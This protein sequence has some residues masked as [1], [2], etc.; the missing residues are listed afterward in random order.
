MLD[1]LIDLALENS[2]LILDALFGTAAAIVAYKV[3][4]KITPDNVKDLIREAIKSSKQKIVEK[5]VGHAVEA[6]IVSKKSNAV[7]F[8]IFCAACGNNATEKITLESSRGVDESFKKG[9]KIYL[10]I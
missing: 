8:E 7:S 9:D 10:E 6:T 2:D 3:I 1:I 4:R 5:Y